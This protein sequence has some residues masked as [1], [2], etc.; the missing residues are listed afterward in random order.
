VTIIVYGTGLANGAAAGKT[1]LAYLGSTK[2]NVTY[3]GKQG[4]YDGL[5]QYNIE[6]PRSFA[7]QGT[8]TLSISADGNPATPLRV[9]N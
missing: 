4:Q 5:D 7:G 6:I 1:V 8:L 9:V 2:L 3:A